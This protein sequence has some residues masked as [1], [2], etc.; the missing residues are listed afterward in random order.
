MKSAL[1]LDC[2]TKSAHRV[3]YAMKQRESADPLR[4]GRAVSVAIVVSNEGRSAWRERSVV[5]TLAATVGC[6]L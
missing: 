5:D 3:C 2:E 1:P 6:I 4:K